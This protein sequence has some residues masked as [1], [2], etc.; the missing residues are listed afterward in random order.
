MRRTPRGWCLLAVLVALALVSTTGRVVAAANNIY[1]A[2]TATGA[3][4]GQSCANA[5]A[6]TFF[7]TASNWETGANQIG[8]G[9]TVNLCGTIA[10]ELTAHGSG[11]SGS[12]ITISFQSTAQISL[13]ACDNS[14]GC[15]NVSGK[16][17]IIVDGGTPCGPGTACSASLSGTGIIQETANGTGLRYSQDSIAVNAAGGCSNCEFRNLIIGPLYQHTSMSDTHNFGADGAI[18]VGGCSGCTI[19]IHDST[20]HDATGALDYIPTT[21]DNGLQVY[22][23]A[24]YNV[25]AGV[26][27]AGSSSGNVLIAAQIH[28]N[29]IHDEA[30]WDATGCPYHHDGIHA[31]GEFGGAVSGVNFYNNWIGGNFGGCPTGAIFFEGYT[32][33]SLFYNNVV[34]TTYTQQNNPIVALSGFNLTVVNNTLIGAFQGSDICFWTG[35]SSD[36]SLS[37]TPSITFENNIISGCHT[38]TDQ[39]QSPV[40]TAWDYNVYGGNNSNPWYVL[41]ANGTQTW[42]PAL[43]GWQSACACDSHSKFGSSQTYAE[44]NTDGTLQAGSPAAGAGANLASLGIALLDA[45]TTAGGTRTPT[46]RPASGAWSVGAYNAAATSSGTPAAPGALTVTVH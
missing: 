42:Y 1:I 37:F 21:G 24:A 2:Q 13:P 30:N 27:V 4:N 15:L 31:W 16:S 10:A 34:N 12:P 7:N 32:H 18:Y 29:Y 33:D 22:N 9:T 41:R 17:Y 44:V 19:K 45:D 38:L 23:N 39:G 28:D 25:N 40:L 14:N 43:G 20:I 11:S 6:Y 35:Y 3:N 26:A 36:S 8:P 46:G 5:Y